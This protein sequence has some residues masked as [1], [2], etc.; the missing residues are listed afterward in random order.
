MDFI[1]THSIQALY[2]K[3]VRKDENTGDVTYT[4]TIVPD[5]EYLMIYLPKG[6]T[7]VLLTKLENAGIKQGD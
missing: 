7:S 1:T 4:F 6:E 5:R 2:V 3:N